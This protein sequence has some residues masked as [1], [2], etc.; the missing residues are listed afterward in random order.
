[1]EDGELMA[2]VQAGRLDRMAD[3]FE[4]HAGPLLGFFSRL[5]AR[6][7]HSEDLVQEV[8]CRM[9]QYRKSFRAGSAF[10]P[11]MYQIARNVHRRH[12]KSVAESGNDELL[13]VIPDGSESAHARLE[14]EHRESLLREALGR[15]DP[16]KCELLLLS[17]QPEL[18]YQQIAEMTGCS[19]GAVKVQVH[20]A[21]KEL[22]TIYQT[23]EGGAA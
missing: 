1:M 10:A 18:S 13:E 17:R 6:R 9:L 20:R 7:G 21:L 2:Q 22:R 16:R 8:F 3:L 11:W 5:T 12:A 23:L 4:R 15:I 19:V 14:R